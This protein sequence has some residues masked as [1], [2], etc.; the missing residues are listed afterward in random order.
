MSNK[1]RS[2]NAAHA[3]DKP[4]TRNEETNKNWFLSVDARETLCIPGYVR[5]CDNPEVKMAINWLADQVSSMTIH[6]MENTDSGDIRIRDEL[7]RK[8]DIEP[9]PHMTRKTFIS[10]IVRTLF[11]EGEGNQ[12]TVPITKRGLLDELKPIP[13][14]LISFSDQPDGSY[15]VNVNGVPFKDS[16]ILH[17]VLNPD[18]AR[19]HM[20]TGFRVCLA[21]VVNNLKQAAATKKGFLADKWKPSVIIRVSDMPDLTPEGRRKVMQEYM[22]PTEAGEPWL[23]PSDVMEVQTVK[24]LSLQDL[25]LNENVLLDKKTVAS[26]FGVPLYAVGAGGFNKDE[27]NNAIRNKVKTIAE[28]IQQEMTRKL[29]ISPRRYFLL[30]A[31]SLYAYDMKELSSV[32]DTLA[33]HGIMTGNEVRNWINLPPRE[34]LDELKALENYIPLEMIGVQK[35]LKG[36]DDNAEPDKAAE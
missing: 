8:V 35:K 15:S 1:N 31:R 29:L 36:S 33:S 16:D 30:N 14:S 11:I 26:M 3:R 13:A 32:G 20:G 23:V 9:N 17:F 27:H 7:S 22:G 4:I 19:P 6:L 2:R 34:G 28:I 25:A 5:F 21:D 18:P 10:F 24:P 12:I